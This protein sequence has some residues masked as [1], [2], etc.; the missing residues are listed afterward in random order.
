MK[1]QCRTLLAA[2]LLV[3][4]L[5]ASA[6]TVG[7]W[8]FESASGFANDTSINGLNLST[9]GTAPTLYTLPASGPGSKFS[10]TLPQLRLTNVSAADFGSSPAGNFLRADAPALTVINFTIEA[11]VH[12]RSIPSNTTYIAGQYLTSGNQKSWGFGVVGLGTPPA[13][14]TNKELFLLLSANGS[15]NSVVG[16]QLLVETNTDYYVAASFNATDPVS[17]I[18]FYLQNLT[19]NGSL[20]TSVTTNPYTTLFNSTANFTIG[21]YQDSLNRWPGIIDEVRFSSGVLP[22]S[23]LLITL[24]TNLPSFNAEPKSLAVAANT[25]ATFSVD[26]SGGRPLS[27]QWRLGGT[28]LPGETNTSLVVTN[29]TFAMSGN[30]YSVVVTNAQGSITSSNA[31]LTVVDVSTVLDPLRIALLGTNAFLSWPTQAGSV[32]LYTATDLTSSANWQLVSKPAV[33]TG[34]R[35][36]ITLPIVE[37]RQWFRLLPP[38]DPTGVRPVDWSL[39][40]AGQPPGTNAQRMAD[41]LRNACKYAVTTWWNLSNNYAAQN[42]AIYLD[43]GGTDEPHIRRPASEA[44]GLAVALQTGIY[45]PTLAN[46]TAAEARS[47]TVKLVRSLAYS[48]LANKAGGW[49]NDWQTALWAGLT[50]SAGWMLWTNLSAV[51]QEY[52]RRMV[53]YEAHRFTNYTVPYYMNRAGTIVF[54]GDTKGEENAWNASV[55]NLALCMMPDHPNRPLWWTK[56]LELTLS[57]RARPSDIN[58]TNIYHGRTLASWLN[59]SNFNEDSTTINH[60]IVHVDYMV[61][62]IFELQPYL[63]ADRPIPQAGLFNLD[64]LY[65]ALVDLN[66][67]AGSTPYPSGGA[68]QAPGGTIYVRDPDNLPSGDLYYPQGN[69]WGTMRRMNVAGV[70]ATVSQL[71]L[72]GLA[73]IPGELWEAQHA[74]MV[75]D[76]QGRFSDGRT[77]GAASEDT[78]SGREEWVMLLASKAYLLK[79]LAHQGPILISNDP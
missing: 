49:G 24:N 43:L 57:A 44:Y 60:G 69:D 56:T 38:P 64:E 26:A 50:G 68:I 34:G 78:Y 63:L 10:R 35:F 28:P 54:P 7:H 21:A 53:E 6:A 27:Y 66:F 12:R 42:A 11:F 67:V 31:V 22:A 76:M 75:L 16:S 59:G 1:E 18:T 33:I 74:Q 9:N 15:A 32:V 48:H 13:G 47:R 37:P 39:F 8:R 45:D 25:D 19:T 73:S 62:Q 65:R 20:V 4:A 23:D 46:V 71:G 51:D 40:H 36:V 3:T 77:Y 55:L 29:A 17:G 70:D 2:A 41:I 61:A 30:Q 14:T 72:D 52:V 5:S 58:R 79:W